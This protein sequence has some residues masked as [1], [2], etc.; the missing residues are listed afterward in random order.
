MSDALLASVAVFRARAALVGMSREAA[1][2]AVQQGIGSMGQFGFSTSFIPGPGQQDEAPL[3][4]LAS[5]LYK[6]GETPPNRAQMTAVRRLYL[7]VQGLNI[8]PSS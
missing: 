1:E 2:E 4:E 7:E 3:R 6:L 5:S 8:G